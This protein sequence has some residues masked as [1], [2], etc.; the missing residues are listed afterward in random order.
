MLLRVESDA[1][2]GLGTT[3]TQLEDEYADLFAFA[4]AQSGVAVER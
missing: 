2:H 1:G 3:R 4:L